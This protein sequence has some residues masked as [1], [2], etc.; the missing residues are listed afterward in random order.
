MLQYRPLQ[1]LICLTLA[2]LL[3]GTGCKQKNP[4][5]QQE[6]AAGRAVIPVE[7]AGVKRQALTVTK[8]YTGTLEGEEQANIVPKLAERI[9]GVRVRV[10]DAVRAG[11]VIVELDKG[12]AT[13]QYFQADASFR[14]AEKTYQ[15]MKSLYEEGAVSLQV[16]DG[17]QTAYE[18]SKANFDA[19]RSA[20]ELTTPVSGLVTAVNNS[21]GDLTSPGMVVATVARINRM[22]VIFNAS[23]TD[24]PRLSVGQMV[25]VT[26]GTQEPAT[27]SIIQ[28]S[29]SADVRSRSFEIRALFPNTKERGYRPGIYCT[30]EVLLTT[31]GQSL[32][33]PTRAIQSDGLTNRVFVVRDGRSYLR[34]VAVGVSDGVSSEILGGL[35][36]QDTVITTGATSARDS[37]YVN[38]AAAPAAEASAR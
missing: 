10:G 16:L 8:S 18:V 4:D 11:Q 38:I 15:R 20:V 3:G 30:V 17:A 5:G 36:G 26:S 9:T 32:V 31:T 29:K 7:V 22:K 1:S 37:G 24:V 34:E 13:S 19:A 12:G 33:I 14:N 23:E 6:Q 28:I 35:G 21:V 25:R 27:G 2:A